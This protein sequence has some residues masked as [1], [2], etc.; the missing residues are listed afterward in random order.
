MVLVESG[1]AV[2]SLCHQREREREMLL[3]VACSIKSFPCQENDKVSGDTSLEKECLVSFYSS[4]RAY[5]KTRV[6]KPQTLLLE[7]AAKKASSLGKSVC[8]WEVPCLCPN[9]LVNRLPGARQ[10]CSSKWV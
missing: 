7:M 4:S 6:C 10:L 5:L 9:E 2:V 1:N 8:P 3:E